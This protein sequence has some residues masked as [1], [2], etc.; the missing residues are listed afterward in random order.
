MSFDNSYILRNLKSNKGTDSVFSGKLGAAQMNLSLLSPQQSPSRNAQILPGR[1][2]E[3]KMSYFNMYL[4]PGQKRNILI[5]QKNAHNIRRNN[6]VNK[7]MQLD[8][9]RLPSI[10]SIKSLVT[11]SALHSKCIDAEFMDQ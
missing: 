10:N 11:A 7:S 2:S 6:K 3:K 4:S 8:N 9:P 5:H 1:I